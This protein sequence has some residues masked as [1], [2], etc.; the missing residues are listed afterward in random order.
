[1]EPAIVPIVGGSGPVHPFVVDLGQPF[2]TCGCGYP[3]CKAHAPNENLRIADLI[4]GAKHTAH[5]LA[6]LVES[7]EGSR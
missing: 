4:L 7:Y 1:M 6:G 5:F 3:G 2:V